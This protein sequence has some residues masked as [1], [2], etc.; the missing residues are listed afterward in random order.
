MSGWSEEF[1][2]TMERTWEKSRVQTVD[3]RCHFA[4]KL[5]MNGFYER[6]FHLLH[7]VVQAAKWLRNAWDGDVL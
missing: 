7:S 4:L 2:P 1:R 3:N 6:S 5:A